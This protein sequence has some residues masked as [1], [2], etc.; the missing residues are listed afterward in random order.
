VVGNNMA[1]HAAWQGLL[2]TGAVAN[3][4]VG[5]P[6]ANSTGGSRGLTTQQTSRKPLCRVCPGYQ[7]PPQP[8]PFLQAR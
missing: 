3:L 4:A 2:P 5:G 7:V 8:V 1:Q 6:A